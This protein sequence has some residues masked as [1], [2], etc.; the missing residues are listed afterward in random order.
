MATVPTYALDLTGKLA[1]N[2]IV[3]ERHVV[4]A[5]NW[6]SYHFIVPRK[7]P[8]FSASLKVR[9]TNSAGVSKNL[10]LGRDFAYSFW[11]I[12]ASRATAKPVYGGISLLNSELAGII[13]IEY[14]TLGGEYVLD[15]QQVQ[16]ILGDVYHNPLGTSWEQIANV[17]QVFPPSPHEWDLVDMVGASQ[18]NTAIH[19]IAN[20]LRTKDAA[21]Q[22]AHFDAR[23]NP[24]QVTKAQVGLGNVQNF[25]LTPNNDTGKTSTAHNTYMTPAT[26]RLI[27]A[28]AV[29][30]AFTAFRNR[31]DNPHGVT[32][33]Q[34]GAYTKAEANNLLAE[35]LGRDEIAIDSA[36]FGG[37][38]FT[39]A[40]EDI[41][42]GTAAN[43][44]LWNG[45]SYTDM[46]AEVEQTMTAVNTFGGRTPDQN[47]AWVLQG[48]AA[49]AS[50]VYGLN[51]AELLGEFKA[52]ILAAV[53]T[54]SN[55][56][57]GVSLSDI[58]RIIAA[59]KTAFNAT[60][61][62]NRTEAQWIAHLKTQ[63]MGDSTR[64]NGKTY[65]EAKA[66]F[67]SS[68]VQNALNL[69]GMDA[70]T[71][72]ERAE[73]QSRSYIDQQ[74]GNI[75]QT[76]TATN[77]SKL[78]NKTDT[79][80]INAAVQQAV[81]T[82]DVDNK[83]ARALEGITID[84]TQVA[85]IARATK[86]N[87]AANADTLGGQDLASIKT[88]I[89][90]AVIA[91]VQAISTED[92]VDHVMGQVSE[93]VQDAI[94]KSPQTITRIRTEDAGSAT[95]VLVYMHNNASTGDDLV[96]RDYFVVK[97]YGEDLMAPTPLEMHVTI[98]NKDWSR[99]TNFLSAE[100]YASGKRPL[101]RDGNNLYL[102]ENYEHYPSDDTATRNNISSNRILYDTIGADTLKPFDG[103]RKL[104]SGNGL[105][106]GV[107]A[108]VLPV[109]NYYIEYYGQGKPDIE[110]IFV[111]PTTGLGSVIALTYGGTDDKV[112]YAKYYLAKRDGSRIHADYKV[113]HNNLY[114]GKL[115]TYFNAHQ[116]GGAFEILITG[117]WGPSGINDEVGQNKSR[118]AF[119]A[120][121]NID[122][123]SNKPVLHLTVEDGRYNINSLLANLEIWKHDG[124]YYL[125]NN[126]NNISMRV[127]VLVDRQ[128]MSNVPS[129][130]GQLIMTRS[131]NV[132]ISANLGSKIDT[133]VTKTTSLVNIESL[134]DVFRFMNRFPVESNKI[135]LITRMAK[136]GTGLNVTSGRVHGLITFT[137][138]EMA[139]G[140]STI[141]GTNRSQKLSVSRPQQYEVTI[142]AIGNGTTNDMKYSIAKIANPIT[143][144]TY[145]NDR[146]P[147]A[148][149][150]TAREVTNSNGSVDV[151]F[152]LSNVRGTISYT[153]SNSG[154]FLNYPLGFTET[155]ANKLNEGTEATVTTENVDK[156]LDFLKVGAVANK[157]KDIV[158]YDS[159]APTLVASYT[160]PNFNSS[161]SL[162][163]LSN[164][165]NNTTVSLKFTT[166]NGEVH[167]FMYYQIF[168]RP[169]DTVSL[170]YVHYGDS[171]LPDP[172]LNGIEFYMQVNGRE[173]DLGITNLPSQLNN[174]FLEVNIHDPYYAERRT[175][176]TI[177]PIAPNEYKEMPTAGTKYKYRTVLVAS[178]LF[179]DVNRVRR[180]N[181]LYFNSRSTEVA[182]GVHFNNRGGLEGNR[183]VQLTG[184]E[185]ENNY[186]VFTRANTGNLI[187]LEIYFFG[188]LSN[189]SVR[190]TVHG[191]L[192]SKELSELKAI[193]IH[194]VSH[195]R[196]DYWVIT[197]LTFGWQWT[198]RSKSG[199]PIRQLNNIAT[200]LNT[201]TATVSI[202]DNMIVYLKDIDAAVTQQLTPVIQSITDLEIGGRNLVIM[203]NM[204]RAGFYARTTGT[205][206]SSATDRVDETY[207]PCTENEKFVARLFEFTGN[208]GAASSMMFYNASKQFVSG[209]V[210]TTKEIGRVFKI[211]APAGAAFYRLSILGQN[212]KIKLERGHHPT[213]W[214][215]APEDLD[216]SAALTALK[217]EFTQAKSEYDAYKQNIKSTTGNIL[218]MTNSPAGYQTAATTI[219]ETVTV[220]DTDGCLKS[221]RTAANAMVT[222]GF[223]NT[224]A[225]NMEIPIGTDLFVSAEY[226]TNHTGKVEFNLL[227]SGARTMHINPDA[228]NEDGTATWKRAS[229]KVKTTKAFSAIS[230][231]VGL[232]NSTEGSYIKVRNFQ[233]AFGNE[234]REYRPNP[235]D[236]MSGNMNLLNGTQPMQAKD[237]GNR[238]HTSATTVCT[239]ENGKLVFT[240]GAAA[241]TTWAEF[242]QASYAFDTATAINESLSRLS[243]GD[244]VTISFTVDNTSANGATINA[245]IRQMNPQYNMISVWSH[246]PPNVTGYRITIKT[247]LA[248]NAGYVE[249]G[250]RVAYFSLSTAPA[251]SVIRVY[252]A[253]ITRGHI[254]VDAGHSALDLIRYT[255]AE[256][257]KAVK[258]TELN[259]EVDKRIAAQVPT[260]AGTTFDTKFS[261][262]I[263]TYQN[264]IAT[265]ET[266]L[267]AARTKLAEVDTVVNDYLESMN[268]STTLTMGTS[269]IVD[270][271]LTNAGNMTVT[272]DVKSHSTV[273]FR[274]VISEA[275]KR[276]FEKGTKI[277]MRYDFIIR[278]STGA[279]LKDI[280]YQLVNA[281][282]RLF[283]TATYNTSYP[284]ADYEAREG[285]P[286][287]H[288]F[289]F[290]IRDVSNRLKEGTWTHETGGYFR[291]NVS[292]KIADRATFSATLTFNSPTT[293]GTVS[294]IRLISYEASPGTTAEY[295]NQRFYMVPNALYADRI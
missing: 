98:R 139:G 260:I 243:R 140:D 155:T 163:L 3:N 220:L 14:Q 290:G 19:E 196:I 49:N 214:T 30:D 182:S 186:A 20:V 200:L 138:E 291:A 184:S 176:V 249:N 50:E 167:E 7:G 267:S 219:A 152:Y 67:T 154:S 84:N 121:Y 273:R 66:D 37:M 238:K 262:A 268:R 18:L 17:P 218:H 73:A 92:V 31:R 83:I 93:A 9:H 254:A 134:H 68:T 97:N 106:T 282:G 289:V 111:S 271:P 228:T 166:D 36:R 173:S 124:H 94:K 168:G 158:R 209:F 86:V 153:D 150:I 24:H 125:K 266:Q 130:S 60:K 207:Y 236:A 15:D 57:D 263:A 212:V 38:T 295:R 287:A 90:D 55:T 53:S 149:R 85:N 233:I 148:F 51:K 199:R 188:G 79:Q 165:S 222:F 185:I 33:A 54:D 28:H 183:T 13:T 259:T 192:S 191:T 107:T 137:I 241:S 292:G 82:V 62:N 274:F 100:I 275:M 131:S 195:N 286:A 144:Q 89:S 265:L 247:K 171:P 285:G 78:N 269:N 25:G 4:T 59:E 65:T 26:T 146:F 22:Q 119:T 1:A 156:R 187:K 101:V 242:Y 123:T 235:N 113:R 45:R 272:I 161:K 277:E 127:Q 255:D 180:E 294:G 232:I 88:E 129:D 46:I 248:D 252:D 75:S 217:N 178:N 41:L 261:T 251:N 244:D 117:F 142:T 32:A 52:D 133:M 253:V 239:V 96:G 40:K 143:S 34:T 216:E 169:T 48:T 99:T 114:L 141:P 250:A 240:T 162:A 61:F 122:H 189:P 198:I 21:T 77:A 115:D 11:Y 229:F 201:P 270:I 231:Y 193:R 204:T 213:D 87:N 120:R 245:I 42:T 179:A 197:N 206:S 63:V 104:I 145:T 264:R 6:R 128:D 172:D 288:D 284:F 95:H 10:Q 202:T 230:L 76:L 258:K 132:P 44:V 151:Y 257:R 246:V 205:L 136:S 118:T 29:G 103:L 102:D 174:S 71:I 47:K 279:R 278:S 215:P 70:T 210:I 281:S 170:N 58:Y 208:V 105:T 234:E 12:G 116:T 110:N 81:R 39:E 237:W 283:N 112:D 80:I 91:N 72:I 223:R 35:K 227:N 159:M 280:V 27:I 64:F 224:Q 16:E 221:T 194:K 147:P 8:Y 157:L 135:Y 181:E 225:T 211:T 109:G 276:A 203:K 5:A 108:L 256:F 74:I 226:M 293:N 69:N 126:I 2:K 190:V 23:N 164:R 177:R 160:V 56:L 43:A 175:D